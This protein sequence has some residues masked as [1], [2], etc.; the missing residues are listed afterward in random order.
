MGMTYALLGDHEFRLMA[1][2]SGMSSTEEEQYADH[3]LIKG[4]T[5]LEHVGQG[6]DELVLSISLNRELCVVEDEMAQ[7]RRLKTERQVLPLV[8]GNGAY[9]GRYVLTKLH[10]VVQQTDGQGTIISMTVDLTLREYTALP[11]AAVT[12]AAPA[13]KGAGGKRKQGGFKTETV[14]NADGYPS[15]RV[16]RTPDKAAS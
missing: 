7:L 3:T 9:Q 1:Y 11:R 12:K 2:W 4:K 13:I 15:T 8:F 16:V 6:A 14:T 10:P 5:V